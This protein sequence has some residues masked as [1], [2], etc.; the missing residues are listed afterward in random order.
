MGRTDKL[1][2]GGRPYLGTRQCHHI[3]PSLGCTF[4]FVVWVKRGH[5]GGFPQTL[6]PLCVHMHVN[7]AKFE[8]ILHSNTLSSNL[9]VEKT[10]TP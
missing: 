8:V 2:T 4:F 7:E 6:Y 3:N 10:V 9:S 5:Q 1:H